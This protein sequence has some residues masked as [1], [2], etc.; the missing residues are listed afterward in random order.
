[1]E[2]GS[3]ITPD[4]FHISEN[5]SVEIEKITVQIVFCERISEAEA[6][7]RL[8]EK[9]WDEGFTEEELRFGLYMLAR[10]FFISTTLSAEAMYFH[11][12]TASWLNSISDIPDKALFETLKKENRVFTTIR[13][14]YRSKWDY[15]QGNLFNKF[16]LVRSG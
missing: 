3:K 12:K 14:Y 2:F 7:D 5:R 8:K 11:M 10:H 15:Y 9:A 13:R 6:I 4:S 1:M 16:K